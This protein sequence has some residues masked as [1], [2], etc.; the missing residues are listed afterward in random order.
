[1][2]GITDIH[3]LTP[4]KAAQYLMENG[5]KASQAGN[6]FKDI[7]VCGADCFDD[8]KNTSLK[9]KQKLKEDFSFRKTELI[10]RTG[11]CDTEK[12]L[13]KLS[14][15]NT[16]ETVI[17]KQKF[18][19]S[20]CISTQSGCNMGCKFCCSGK[21]KKIRDLTAG[22]MVQ[23]VLFSQKISGVKV[24]NITVMG[25]G[26]PFDNY[27]N[28]CDFLDIAS[29]GYGLSVGESH[30]TVS[31]CGIVPKTEQFSKREK[32]CNLAIS[33]HAPNDSIRSRIM[34]VNKR[35]SINEV[36]E[37]VR[38][39]ADTTGK[40]VLIEYILLKGIND[41]RDNAKELALLLDG[42][43]FLVNLIPYNKADDDM[44]FR[45]D[46]EH[47]TAFYDELKKQGMNVTRRKEF[48]SSLSAACGQLRSD[49][50]KFLN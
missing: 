37:S 8:M 3:S 23:Q 31:T 17:M 20:I 36:V 26:E 21:L 38:M 25:I 12:Y 15:G 30:I 14:D 41:S 18:G 2:Q 27:E 22:E 32:P 49:R 13:F 35:Y 16:V 4:T 24:S 6:I 47:I 48:G 28:L 7:Y 29:Y 1:M 50:E 46:E 34:P 5:F 19:N 10:D 42:G 9:V 45:S 43:N 40:K 33:L 39:Y 44:F 11:D